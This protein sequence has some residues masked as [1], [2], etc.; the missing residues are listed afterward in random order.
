MQI[1]IT[2][3]SGFIGNSIAKSLSQTHTLRAM[4]R[5]EQSDQALVEIGVKPLRSELGAVKLEHLAG[6]Q[7]V[8]HCAAFAKQWGTREQFWKTNVD[9]T[10]QLLQIARQAGVARFI[11]IGTEAALFHGQDM[12]NIDETYP[13]PAHTPFLYSESKGAA[14]KLV[15]AAN[16]PG[17]ETLSLR[18][19][20]VWGPG[21]QTV[22]L[23][24]KK[25]VTSGRFMWINQGQARTS[26]THVANVVYAVTLALQRG[27]G[28][29]AYF[30]TDSTTTT[31]REFLTALLK[32]QGLTPPNT[33]VPSPLARAM[34]MVVEGVWGLLGLKTEPPLTRLAAAMMSSECTICID[35]AHQE[36]D[37][38]PIITREQ[39]LAE[40][41]IST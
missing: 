28:G 15:L 25:M 33:S 3:A 4:S 39:G 10:S 12:H 36:L 35:K 8:I 21:D 14:E 18:P 32:T 26:T 17:F 19:R 7:A 1:F 23:V 24:L 40:L 31:L 16:A 11:Y 5:S 6:C 9:G 34:A 37:Y 2:G 13:Y 29:Q 20:L 38:K 41:T 30:I 27:R 22:L